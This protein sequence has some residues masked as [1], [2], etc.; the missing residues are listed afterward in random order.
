MDCFSGKTAG[1]LGFWDDN[2]DKEFLL[3]NGSF[4]HTNSSSET[5][6]KEFGEKCKSLFQSSLLTAVH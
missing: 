4:I 3:P 1:L 5:L 2:K 6:H